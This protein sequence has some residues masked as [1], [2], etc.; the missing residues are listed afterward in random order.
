MLQI[1]DTALPRQP[2]P[3]QPALGRRYGKVVS[4][5]QEAYILSLIRQLGPVSRP[6]ISRLTG[7]SKTA[8]NARLSSLARLGLIDE[9]PGG[10]SRGGRPPGLVQ[11]AKDA[12]RLLGVDLGVTSVDVAVTNLNAELLVHVSHPIDVRSGPKKS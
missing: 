3:A 1:P 6:D 7:L 12:G 9:A 10:Q 11:F 8:V 2:M 5:P 4:S